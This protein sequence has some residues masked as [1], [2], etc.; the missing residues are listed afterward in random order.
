MTRKAIFYVVTL[1]LAYGVIELMS[2]LAYAVVAEGTFSFSQL[3]EHRS[4]VIESPAE[5]PT[6]AAQGSA[7]S[8]P[9]FL[10]HQVVHPFS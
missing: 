4:A 7:G 5:A 10:D 6:L 8:R 9:Q 3:Q 2:Y 1:L